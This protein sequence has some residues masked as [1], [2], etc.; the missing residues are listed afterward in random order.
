MPPV[1]RRKRLRAPRGSVLWTPQIIPPLFRDVEGFFYTCPSCGIHSGRCFYRADPKYS[2]TTCLRTN[3]MTVS[4][5][6]LSYSSNKP[7]SLK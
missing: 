5:E 7:L 6:R 4:N 1:T 3:R 2:Q